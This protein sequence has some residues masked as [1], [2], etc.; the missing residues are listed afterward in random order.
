M[1][2]FAH[3]ALGRIHRPEHG[4]PVRAGHE[5]L[6]APGD[7][8]SRLPGYH[9]AGRKILDTTR[10]G[11]CRTSLAHRSVPLQKRRIDSEELTGPGAAIVTTTRHHTAARQHPRFRVL[12]VRSPHATGTDDGKTDGHAVT[13]HGGRTQNAGAGPGYARA[14]LPGKA[15]TAG[16][17]AMELA[18]KSGTDTAASC[19]QAE[20]CLRRRDRLS[21]ISRARQ[22]CH[23]V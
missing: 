1:D 16:R 20:G 3:G 14:E 17:S 15:R 13:R 8:L 10:G 22:E 21:R 18:R 23:P 9:P 12:R 2:A 6:S 11:G 19:R 4:A 7:G 5:R